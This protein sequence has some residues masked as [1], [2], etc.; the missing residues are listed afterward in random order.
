VRSAALRT[1]RARL[2]FLPPV[3]LLGAWALLTWGAAGIAAEAAPRYVAAVWRLS[4]GVLCAC[5]FGLG[6]FRTIATEGMYALMR[7]PEPKHRG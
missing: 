2:E 3:L 5:L 7:A 6:L 1:W 4:G